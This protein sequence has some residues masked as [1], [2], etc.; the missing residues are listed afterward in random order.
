MSSQ[1][2]EFNAG[3]QDPATANDRDRSDPATATQ[4]PSDRDPA[5]P[6]PSDRDRSDPATA[7]NGENVPAVDHGLG[8]QDEDADFVLC[9]GRKRVRGLQ[10]QGTHSRKRTS[11]V[12][13]NQTCFF[14]KYI[15]SGFILTLAT[16]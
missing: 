13:I 6:R 4:R 2:N 14:Y 15:L 10:G 9:R 3:E 16:T 12:G 8:E 1:T 5:T 7:N 11:L